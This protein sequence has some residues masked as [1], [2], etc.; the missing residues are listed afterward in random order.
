MP[1]ISVQSEEFQREHTCADVAME[2]HHHPQRYCLDSCS[3]M[4][5]LIRHLSQIQ[6]A[7]L[8]KSYRV[9]TIS[10]SF[11]F[12]SLPFNFDKTNL[13]IFCF[14]DSEFQV[15]FKFT[16]TKMKISSCV[17]FQ[18]LYCLTFYITVCDPSIFYL[19]F[20]IH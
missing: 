10:I 14:R 2:L 4:S 5:C 7:H 15:L 11:L 16:F 13:P 20:Q 8:G 1:I 17:T 3:Q 19:Y 12:P 6:P 9:L 18:K